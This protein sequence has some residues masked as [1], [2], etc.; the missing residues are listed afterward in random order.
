MAHYKNIS[1]QIV[2]MARIG[3]NDMIQIKDMYQM[4][5]AWLQ[6]GTE[7]Y[8]KCQLWWFKT[9]SCVTLI[10]KTLTGYMIMLTLILAKSWT[11]DPYKKCWPWISVIKPP[12]K[13]QRKR[14]SVRLAKNFF[15]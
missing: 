15:I 14:V 9:F 5:P 11:V 6:F 10:A 13:Y 2:H 4:V 7:E 3:E 12:E 1:I 8:K